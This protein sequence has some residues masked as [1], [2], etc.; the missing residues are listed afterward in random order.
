[1]EDNYCRMFA[2]SAAIHRDAP[3]LQTFGEK[4]GNVCTY[5]KI[6]DETYA[7][8]SALKNLGIEKADR[9][10]VIGENHPRWAMAYL[11]A[12]FAEA[13]VVPLDVQLSVEELRNLLEDS[14]TRAIFS[15]ATQLNKVLAARDALAR[16]LDIICLGPDGSRGDVIAM[17]S[18][19]AGGRESH[20]ISEPPRCSKDDVAI[21]VYT[22]GTTGRPKGVMITHHNL[23]AQVKGVT[24]CLN[25][26]AN[27]RL[28][29]LLPLHHTYAQLGN[30][31][32]PLALGATV[33]YLEKVASPSLLLALK[34]CRITILIGVPQLYYLFHQRIFDAVRSRALPVRVFFRLLFGVSAFAMRRANLR[35]GKLLF[36]GIHKQFG[37][38]IR[39]MASAGSSFDAKVARDLSALGFMVLQGYGLTETSGAATITPMRQS[40]VGTVGVPIPGAEVA[41]ENPDEQGIGEVIIKGDVVMKGYYNRA[42]VTAEIIRDGWFHSGDLGYLDRQGLLY[43]TGRKKDVIVLSSGK[44]IYPEEIENHYMASPAIREMCVF[45]RRGEG[46]YEEEQLFA[47]V[48]PNFD[49][50]RTQKIANA[51]EVIRYDIENLSK[52][53]PKHKRILSYRI[54][55]APLPRTSTRKIKRFEVRKD[56]EQRTTTEGAPASAPKQDRPDPM[57]ATPVGQRVA[58]VIKAAM[59]RPAS[60]SSDSNIELDLGFD[61]LRRIE[62]FSSI[63]EMFAVK[64][65]EAQ[66]AEIYTVGQLIEQTEALTQGQLPSA[67]TAAVAKKSWR[68]ILAPTD[69]DAALD[70]TLP[71]DQ[72]ITI[73]LAYVVMKLVYLLSKAL[74]RLGAKGVEHLPKVRPYLICPNHQSFIDPFVISS[75]Y[76]YSIAKDIFHVGATEYFSNLFTRWF[77]RALNVVP[78]DPDINLHRAMTVAAVGLRRG[79]ILTIYPEGS[80]TP[81]GELKEFKKGAS[82]LATELRVPIV[83]AAISGAY[84]VW[85]RASKRI[86]LAKVR[87]AFGPPIDVAK[88]LDQWGPISEIEQYSRVNEVLRER[89][90]ELLESITPASAK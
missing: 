2:T 33:T 85:P 58:E 77:A 8:A 20:A 47:V 78:V 5:G 54:Q 81:D 88:L 74:F 23:I 1:M 52:S 35:A 4:A 55:S 80:R 27:D 71:H 10:G 42:D 64:F 16:P 65:G 9:V 72:F 15:S 11:G 75:V 39:I 3:A 86:R 84:D 51:G 26:N 44:N 17:E 50:L 41:I 32:M 19:S 73:F 29:G 14:G 28:L 59:T 36:R 45:G 12:L 31:L 61:S 22:S 63:E 21:L 24:S 48:V 38:H 6:L 18:F 43:I 89:V 67:M 30:F 69:E 83:P 90:A 46:R 60:F 53:L 70:R 25:V 13:I 34:E 82:I 37:G 49:Y 57:L 62:L 40:R 56:F 7:L 76:P 68:E 87:V 79:K 66:A